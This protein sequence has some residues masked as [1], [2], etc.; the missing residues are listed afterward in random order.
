MPRQREGRAFRVI[1]Y[2][3]APA[4]PM[5]RV[6]FIRIAANAPPGRGSTRSTRTAAGPRGTRQP[7]SGRRSTGT[8]SVEAP[9]SSQ[10]S[11]VRRKSHASL[12]FSG[13]PSP[14]RGCPS[15]QEATR[16]RQ[17]VNGGLPFARV[18]TVSVDLVCRAARQRAFG[19]ASA[20]IDTRPLARLHFE[21]VPHSS[22][23]PLSA[24]TRI[25]AYIVSVY[26]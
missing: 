23:R 9:W 4:G 6:A 14:V 24:G 21:C 13:A 17:A 18:Q 16:A 3:Q 2:L 11:H 8:S 7:T 26:R 10:S 5:M 22:R 12:M 19:Q 1:G 20:A 25:D 15:C